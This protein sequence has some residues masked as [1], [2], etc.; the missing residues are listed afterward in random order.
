MFVINF[1]NTKKRAADIEAGNVGA[2]AGASVGLGT[3]IDM[4]VASGNAHLAAPPANGKSIE[5]ADSR[6]VVGN[7]TFLTGE[8]VGVDKLVGG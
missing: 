2:G 3:T 6:L 4:D 8:R 7:N 5:M 1:R